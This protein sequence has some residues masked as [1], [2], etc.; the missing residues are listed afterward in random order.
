MPCRHQGGTVTDGAS[1]ADAP[2]VLFY[3]RGASW[4]WLLAGPFAG[5]GM[6]ILQVTGGYGHDLWVPLVFLVLVSG[7]IA[8]QIKAGRI[9]TSVELTAETLRQGAE[10]ISVAEIVRIYPEASGTETPRWQSARALGE[11]SGVPRGRKGIGLKLTG[12]RTA[13]AWA[14]KHRQLRQALTQLVEERIP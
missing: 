14:R 9:H 8:I 6:A 7:F 12:D 3:E 2:P 10:R 13:Q 4:A 1:T 11:L 5:G